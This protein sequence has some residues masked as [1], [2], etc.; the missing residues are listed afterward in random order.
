[1][2]QRLC[3][4]LGGSFNPILDSWPTAELLLFSFLL[5]MLGTVGDGTDNT[6]SPLFLLLPAGFPR[7]STAANEPKQ[8]NGPGLRF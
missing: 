4:T 7:S 8:A 5:N 3:E 2:R 1:M 6:L